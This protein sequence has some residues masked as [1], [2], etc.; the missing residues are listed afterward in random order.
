MANQSDPLH[1]YDLTFI[2]KKS[3]TLVINK[4]QNYLVIYS[5]FWDLFP[6]LWVESLAG[7]PPFSSKFSSEH[8]CIQVTGVSPNSDNV[9]F[10]NK[11]IDMRL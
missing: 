7:A 5:N 10:L 9:I 1:D 8:I 2:V 3:K 4:I 6:I 11:D